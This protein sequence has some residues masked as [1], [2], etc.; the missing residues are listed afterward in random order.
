[1]KNRDVVN[2]HLNDADSGGIPTRRQ[3]NYV[4]M[5]Q[6]RILDIMSKLCLRL[7]ILVVAKQ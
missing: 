1:M 3:L 2:I 6:Q 7:V 4:F 5:Y